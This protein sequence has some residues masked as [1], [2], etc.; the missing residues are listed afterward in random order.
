[1]TAAAAPRRRSPLRRRG[2]A[3]LWAGGLVSDLGDWTLLIGLPVFVF[4]LTGSALTTSTRRTLKY[5]WYSR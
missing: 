1:M 2:F 4:Q 3:L 5:D